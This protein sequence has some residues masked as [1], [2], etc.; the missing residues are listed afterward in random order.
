MQM[1]VPGDWV[2][3]KQNFGL[4][5]K[6]EQID[7]RKSL[8]I[9][10][11]WAYYKGEIT[12]AKSGDANGEGWH[13]TQSIPGYESKFTNWDTALDDYNGGGVENYSDSINRRMD[14]AGR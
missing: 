4:T 2:P 9:A 12:R 7:P 1:N 11:R 3:E 13:D 5:G 6:R 8:Q 10:L 14:N